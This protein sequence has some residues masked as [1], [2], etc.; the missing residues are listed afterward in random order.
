MQ[1]LIALTVNNNGIAT[2]PPE[3]AF[4]GSITAAYTVKDNDGVESNVA[5]IEIQYVAVMSP[6]L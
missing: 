3:K 6:T 4:V 1:I 2:L 5:E